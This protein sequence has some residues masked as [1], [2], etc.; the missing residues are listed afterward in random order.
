MSSPNDNPPVNR[1]EGLG[2]LLTTAG[3][4]CYILGLLATNSYLAALGTTDFP[5]LNTRLVYTG[6]LVLTSL[7]LLWFIAIFVLGLP[8]P[9]GSESWTGWENFRLD[10]IGTPLIAIVAGLWLGRFLVYLC[11]DFQCH[12]LVDSMAFS[13]MPLALPVLATFYSRNSDSFRVDSVS[14]DALSVSIVALYLIS[15][16]LVRWRST[17]PVWNVLIWIT[18]SLSIAAACSI[19]FRGRGQLRLALFCFGLM[20]AAAYVVAQG[21]ED[22]Y[23]DEV[24]SEIRAFTLFN[25]FDFDSVTFFAATAGL[26]GSAL[27]A[28]TALFTILSRSRSNQSVTKAVLVPAARGGY[29]AAL[30]LFLGLLLYAAIFGRYYY[31]RIPETLGGGQAR[32][33]QFLFTPQGSKDASTLGI[34]MC[35]GDSSL[36]TTVTILHEGDNEYVLQHGSQGPFYSSIVTIKKDLVQATFQPKVTV[37]AGVFRDENVCD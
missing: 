27:M 11:S 5:A 36:S 33:A 21:V 12:T 16:F 9:L 19:Q 15:Y 4:V 13:L 3:V 26:I 31:Y 22:A 23:Y 2:K 34:G 29:W 17:V 1:I 32:L 14:A 6:A 30:A 8:N 7:S 28:G 10:S 20:A 18:F 35:P 24:A 25:F 37:D